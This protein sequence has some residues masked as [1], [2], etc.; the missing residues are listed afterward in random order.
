MKSPGGRENS[1][2]DFCC[3]KIHMNYDITGLVRQKIAR[4]TARKPRESHAKKSREKSREKTTIIRRL[5]ADLGTREL[6]QLVLS[7]IGIFGLM[8]FMIYLLKKLQKSGTVSGRNLRVIE[9]TA[10]DREV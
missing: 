8:F 7:L 4:K 10:L 9:R 5:G 1:A 3:T 2:C 6:V